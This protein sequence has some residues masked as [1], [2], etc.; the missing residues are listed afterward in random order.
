LQGDEDVSPWVFLSFELWDYIPT[1]LLVLTVTSRSLGTQ[2]A[3]PKPF[4]TF[5]VGGGGSGVVGGG[6]GGADRQR[7]L[8]ARGAG[9]GYSGYG[10][11]F[12]AEAGVAGGEGAGVEMAYLTHPPDPGSLDRFVP[13]L[14]FISL[15]PSLGRGL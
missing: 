5:L 3:P 2:R 4:P 15:S 11:L 12:D 7:L 9:A 10:G 8:G 1:I 14:S 6:G 13:L